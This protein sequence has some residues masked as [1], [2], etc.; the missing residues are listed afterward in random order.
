[1]HRLNDMQFVRDTVKKLI[2]AIEQNEIT[3]GGGARG[4]MASRDGKRASQAASSSGTGTEM[5]AQG[6]Q[7]LPNLGPGDTQKNFNNS[8]IDFRNGA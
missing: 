4:P 2:Y 7:L 5:G 1:M 6:T 8:F 3:V